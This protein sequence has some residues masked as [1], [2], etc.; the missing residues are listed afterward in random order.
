MIFSEI[1]GSYYKAMAE[2]LKVAIS[3]GGH[4]TIN[5]IRPIIEKYAFA[6]SL[7]SIEP[8]ITEEKW[9]VIRADGV[10]AIS[11]PPIMPLS[12]LEKQWL[13]AISLDPRVKLFDIDFGFLGDVEPLFTQDDYYV[14]DKYGDGDPF[15]DPEYIKNFRLILNALKDHHPL[16]IG[17]TGVEQ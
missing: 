9:Q 4:A 15:E 2:I 3:E 5:D 10:T 17:Q 16:R 8:A 1:Y 14:F 13:K 12:T 11:N 7:L 6:E